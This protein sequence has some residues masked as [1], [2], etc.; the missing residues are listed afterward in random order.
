MA[1]PVSP[2]IRTSNTDCECETGAAAPC[3][4]C[5][6]PAPCDPCEKVEPCDPCAKAAPC[7]PCD[8][9][10]ACPVPCEPCAKA[11]PCPVASCDKNCGPLCTQ[12]APLDKDNL[13]RLQAYAYPRYWN[14]WG[15]NLESSA[16]IFNNGSY[17]DGTMVSHGFDCGCANS[18]L[19]SH[20]SA[21]GI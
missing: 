16:N 17:A 10:P 12:A 1:I 21:T 9:S 14:L 11:A 5:A 2:R 13:G 3:D 18:G 6:E 8:V 7:E 19:F 15:G 20:N 4:P